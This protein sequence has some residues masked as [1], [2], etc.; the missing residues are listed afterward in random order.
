MIDSSTTIKEYKDTMMRCMR[1]LFPEME[2]YEMIDI[3]NYSIN[4]RFKN[5]EA[6]VDNSYTHKVANMDL[7]KVSDYI[8][9]KKPIVTAY[10]TMFMQKEDVVNLLLDVV[11]LFLTNRKMHKKKMFSFPKGTAMFAK[12]NL[13]QILDKID[14]NGIYGVLGQYSSLLFNINVATSITSQGRALVS[15]MTM[16]WEMFLANN[17]LFGSVNEV[18]QYIDNIVSERWQRRY[19]DIDILDRNISVE[20]CFTKIVL[21]CG[22]RWIPNME[23]LNIIW[24]GLVNLTQEDINRIYYKNNLYEFLSNTKVFNIIYVMLKRLKKP[25][26]DPNEVPEEISNHIHIFTD[27]LMEYVYY[28]YAI[29]DRIDRCDNMIKAVTPVSDTDST[30][31]SVDAWYRFVVNKVN[32]EEFRIANYC[33][34]PLI[35]DDNWMQCVEF[36]PKRLDYNFYTDEI[37][38]VYSS[39]HPDILTPNKNVKYSIINILAFVLGK[40]VGDYME[41]TCF[42]FN[43]QK[44]TEDQY[45]FST[46]TYRVRFDPL[47]KNID[48]ELPEYASMRYS[49]TKTCRISAKNEFYFIR[50]LMTLVK[51][52]YASLIGVQE[53]NMVPEDKQLDIKGIE[54]LTKSS[55]SETTRNALKKILLEDILKI[56]KIDQLDQDL[57]SII[58]QS[59]LNLQIPILIQ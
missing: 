44:E 51:K 58:N 56:P 39:S 5:S 55:K 10:G 49:H 9:D 53:G 22:Y 48:N 50:L 33:P 3:L 16:L 4:K 43:S 30:I 26:L 52:N 11:E 59:Q 15:S 47:W 1:L 46:N 6:K 14:N 32:G 12:Y 35:V 18:M 38:E 17:V 40:L 54:C 24:Q 45:I 19:L 27:L 13:M 57:K 20:E 37:E 8:K 29:I 7:L 42:N 2:E 36:E 31:I 21:T 25:Y 23:E 28:H 34:D 41:R